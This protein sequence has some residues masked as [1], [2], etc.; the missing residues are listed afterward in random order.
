M[1]NIEKDSQILGRDK[2]LFRSHLEEASCMAEAVASRVVMYGQSCMKKR[3]LLD[4][5]EAIQL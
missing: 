4:G 3:Q 1:R 5:E 2:N